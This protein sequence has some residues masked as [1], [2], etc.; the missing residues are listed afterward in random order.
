MIAKT[1]SCRIK[2]ARVPKIPPSVNDPRSPI[3]ICAGYVL[4]Q[5]KPIPAP[6]NAPQK[7]INS[8][9][10]GLN[11]IN[12]YS[13]IIKFPS[14]KWKTRPRKISGLHDRFWEGGQFR[15]QS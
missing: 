2:T 6:I 11:G 8:P 5:R 13:D 15:A 12:K 10:R 7:T 1:T 3:K 14:I 9:V 4:Y